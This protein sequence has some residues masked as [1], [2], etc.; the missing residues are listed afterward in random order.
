MTEQLLPA[1]DM[2]NLPSDNHSALFIG[3]HPDD[4]ELGAGGTVARLTDAGWDVWFCILTNESDINVALRRKNEA[5]AAAQLLGLDT[6]KVLFAD[7]PDSDLKCNGETVARFRQLLAD[8]DLNPDIV[9]THSHQD[10]HNDHR[11]SYAICQASFRKK[12]ILSFAVVN[13]LVADKF[14]PRIFSDVSSVYD[15]KISALRMHQS[16][17]SRVNQ[18]SLEKLDSQFRVRLGFTNTEAFELTVQEGANNL[19]IALNLNDCPFHSFWY[20]FLQSQKLMII[21]AQAVHRKKKD[22][23]WTSDKD[24]DGIILLSRAFN[25]LWVGKSPIEDHSSLTEYA[26]SYLETSNVLLSGGAVSN[27]IT[28]EFFNH[29]KGIRYAIDYTMPSYTDIVIG[30]RLKSKRITATYRN[31]KMGR[32]TPLRDLGILT[33]MKNPMA[34][35]KWLMGCMGIHGFG[36]LACFEAISNRLLLKELMQMIGFPFRGRGYQ[37]LVE[38]DTRAEK[39][40]LKK[41]TLYQLPELE[42]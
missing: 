34:E 3:A 40:R 39:T 37:I 26:E 18:A 29:F 5:I 27:R 8:H 21:H 23:H 38:Y 22:F 24:R 6:T 16:Q 17:S 32:R 7:F 13:S 4:I 30:D 25:E 11:A 14:E 35:D 2:S 33:I 42:D 19:R 15:R 1:N 12:V 31:D 9:F 10:S 20:A 36:S 41:A 28:R